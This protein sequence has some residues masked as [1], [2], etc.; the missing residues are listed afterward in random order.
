MLKNRISN[1]VGICCIALLYTA[2]VPFLTRKNENKAVPSTYSNNSQDTTN[3]AK[4]RWKDFFTDPNLIV[5]IDSALKN[6]QA[7]NI[8]MQDI[9]IA[10]NQVRVRKGQYLP[11][12]HLLGGAGLEKSGKYTTQGALENN[13]NI[14][15]APGRTIPES[16]PDYLLAANASWQVDIWKQL[17]NAK[18]S[19]VYRYLSTIEGRKFVITLLIA[20]VASNYY[21]LMTLDNQLD[22][23]RANIEIQTNALEIVKLQKQAGIVTELAVRRFEAEVF[24]N[25]GRQFYIQQRIIEAENRIN[26]LTGRFP[27]P[28]Q[29]SSN[30][31]SDLVPSPM[32]SGVPSQLLQNRTDI[33]QAE[34]ALAAAKLDIKVAKASFYPV[35]NI[36]AGVGYEAF[37]PGYLITTP[38]STLYNLAGS[39]VAPLINRNAIKADYYS[40]N[41]R[42]IQAVYNYERT[43]LNAYVEVSNQLANISNLEK[44]YDFKSK[45][46]QALNRS[47]NISISLF[48]SAMADY[49]E[50]LL[51]QRDALESKMELVET[52]K[53]QLNATVRMYQVLGGGW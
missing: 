16:L 46:V 31:L 29:R 41:A 52:K 6:N 48:K 18:K 53:Q 20:D 24:K 9:V 3:S 25:Q 5:L 32:Y 1:Y 23:L 27:Q 43:V 28:V 51:T 14:N 26:F 22:I 36:T 21:E 13:D 17:R 12:V 39:L 33:T 30:T 34:Q 4:V 47:I 10:N 8:I 42:Q 44:S 11:F 7:L 15:I 49:M 37:K 45:Q 50:V 40:A 19:A 38:K 35:F 2:C